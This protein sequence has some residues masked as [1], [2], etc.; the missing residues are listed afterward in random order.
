MSPSFHITDHA[1]VRYLERIEGVDIQAVRQ[2]LEL[3][4]RH[5]RLASAA[6]RFQ[7]AEYKV[8]SDGI[9][10]VVKKNKVLTCYPK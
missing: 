4:F 9:V 1:V 6:E 2:K 10:V 3:P 7:G 8:K 5:G